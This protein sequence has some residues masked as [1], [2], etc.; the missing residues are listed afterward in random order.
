MG[1]V[2]VAGE[3]WESRGIRGL[4]GQQEAVG[5]QGDSG[6]VGVSGGRRAAGD[7]GTAGCQGKW[8]Q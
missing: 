1:I 5:K 6:T 2:D 4:W 8:G 7:S 3:E